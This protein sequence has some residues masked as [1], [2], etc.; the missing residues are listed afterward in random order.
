MA[1]KNTSV[2]RIRTSET[3]FLCV[4]AD[5]SAPGLLCRAR[6]TF[7]E[8]ETS[9]KHRETAS[10]GNGANMRRYTW[11]QWGDVNAFFGL[12]LDN[13]AVM[14]LLVSVVAQPLVEQKMGEPRFTPEFV[15]TR[16]IPGTALGVLI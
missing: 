10:R 13:L 4:V 1:A 9:S 2:D 6:S 16:M 3:S 14:V 15:M 7:C 5:C 8:R 12:M 11:A